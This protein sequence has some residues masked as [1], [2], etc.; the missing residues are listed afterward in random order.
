MKA[1]FP[2]ECFALASEKK[3][4]N[5]QDVEIIFLLEPSAYFQRHHVGFRECR[6]T[7][8]NHDDSESIFA[9]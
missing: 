9:R 8:W 4:T 3:K 5:V 1:L 7:V 6:G 2:A